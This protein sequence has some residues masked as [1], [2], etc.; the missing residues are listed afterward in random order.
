[1]DIYTWNINESILINI[2]VSDPN[3]GEGLTGETNNIFI[4]IQR[5]SDSRY[6]SGT[7]W[8]SSRVELDVAEVDA[9]NSPGRYT[10][11]LP[12]SANTSANRYI[13][14]AHIDD[15]P[16]IVADSFEMHISRDL[17]YKQYESEPI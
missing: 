8:G 17:T 4:T 16:I 11:T 7:G 15:S 3:T 14:Y 1:M 2:F 10:Y 13:V 9:T 5:T 12:S 6:W